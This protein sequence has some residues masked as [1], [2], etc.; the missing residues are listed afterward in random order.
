MTIGGKPTDQFW[1]SNADE[2]RASDVE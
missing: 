1:R 2:L